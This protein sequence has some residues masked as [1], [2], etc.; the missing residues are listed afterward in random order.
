MKL[1]SL[2]TPPSKVYPVHNVIVG[3]TGLFLVHCT[4]VEG[5][6]LDLTTNKSWRRTCLCSSAHLIC[7]LSNGDMLPNGDAVYLLCAGLPDRE[8]TIHV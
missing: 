4:Q 7:L 1:D 5:A 6:W 3:Y 8:S 2:W